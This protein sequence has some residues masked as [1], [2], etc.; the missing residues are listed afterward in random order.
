MNKISG[1]GSL[2]AQVFEYLEKAILDGALAPGENLTESKISAELGVSRT[3]VREA[4][5]Q[6]EQ[7]GLVSI[8][9]NRGAVVTGIT[10]KDV[11]DIYRMR[12]LIEGMASRMA[13]EN[14]VEAEVHRMRETVD[15]QEFYVLRGD[16]SQAR[17]MDTR[18]HELLYEASR[19]KM[20]KN[21][22][23]SFHN[24]VGR[25]REESF[26]RGDRAAVATQEHR[27]I[28]RAITEGN[29]PQAEELTARHIKNAMENVLK[30]FEK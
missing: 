3:P 28:L 21:T 22:L 7:E 24:Y 27:E 10:Q 20:L 19:S 1:S 4:L 2:T 13:A 11:E 14:A 5:F 26:S 9:R 23:K 6:L 15:L 16:I 18:F 25:A 30:S 29:A 12:M 8:A 17:N